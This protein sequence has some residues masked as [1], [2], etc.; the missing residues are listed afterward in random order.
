MNSSATS[1]TDDEGNSEEEHKIFRYYD[2]SKDKNEHE[3]IKYINGIFWD[4]F[5]KKKKLGEGTS[6]VVRKC[7]RKEDGKVFAVKIVR[8]RDDE[9]IFHVRTS[10]KIHSGSRHQTKNSTILHF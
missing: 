10:P 2:D 4:K 1:T 9:M 8:T 6:G 5:E 3:G 7:I